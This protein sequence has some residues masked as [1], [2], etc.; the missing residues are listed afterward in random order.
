MIKTKKWTLL[1]ALLIGSFSQINAQKIDW[2]MIQIDS[3]SKIDE[4]NDSLINSNKY[5]D[6]TRNGL[7]LNVASTEYY[8]FQKEDYIKEIVDDFIVNNKINDNR[9]KTKRFAIIKRD[10]IY[11]LD[12]FLT[13]TRYYY[14]EGCGV[15]KNI[16]IIGNENITDQNIFCIFN[17]RTEL[18][19]K[20]INLNSIENRKS[21]YIEPK[22]KIIYTSG[23]EKITITYKGTYCFESFEYGGLGTIMPLYINVT[24][25]VKDSEMNNGEIVLQLPH[26]AFF[27]IKSIT[28]AK[29]NSDKYSDLIIEIEDEL[30]IERL[31]YLTN[32]TNGVTQY[33]YIGKM[34]VYCDCP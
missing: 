29:I 12:E 3:I 10:S 24:L 34:E 13:E 8:D 9:T 32:N 21:R 30:C 6:L 5:P 2:S 16:A 28:L 33:D 25:S 11:I 4:T 19:P 17:N 22:N 14:D 27:N 15:I 26:N 18:K 23:F 31:I 20:G 7:V 1:I